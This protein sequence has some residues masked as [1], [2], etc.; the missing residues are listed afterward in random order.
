M[1]VGRSDGGK[2]APV[3]RTGCQWLSGEFEGSLGA[4][5]KGEFGCLAGAGAGVTP[6]NL[7]VWVK[8]LVGCGWDE[9]QG[10]CGCPGELR[11]QGTRGATTCTQQEWLWRKTWRW[12]RNGH[13]DGDT[14]ED[15]ARDDGDDG[16]EDRER[17]RDDGV[18]T[19]NGGRD[20]HYEED[21]DKKWDGDR[22]KEGDRDGDRDSDGDGK[23]VEVMRMRS[24]MGT[25]L[26]AVVGTVSVSVPQ[27]VMSVGQGC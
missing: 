19:G 26:V 2:A 27:T 6:I 24:G 22:D 23:V 7:Q 9:E 1:L 20:W 3:G 12:D 10:V 14:A 5:L 16:V 11:C 21:R 15:R 8:Q 17:D 25:G 13:E 4:F 18:E